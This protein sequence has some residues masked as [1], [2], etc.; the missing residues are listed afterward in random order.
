M[1]PQLAG[2][3]GIGGLQNLIKRSAH[4]IP[5]SNGANT[6]NRAAS[7][8]SSTNPS[9]NSLSISP[10]LWNKPLLMPATSTGDYTPALT[11]GTFTAPDWILVAQNG[12]NPT[13][14][15]TS[16]IASGTS[17]VVGRYA[18]NIYDE[19]GLLDVNVAGY[20]R[21]PHTRSILT[22]TLF[23]YAD[24]TQ[25]GL[26]QNKVDQIVG[27]RNY[28]TTQPS[29]TFPNFSFNSVSAN[30]YY[31]YVSSNTNGFLTPSSATYNAATPNNSFPPPT[32]HQLSP[33]RAWNISHQSS[34]PIS[35]S[36]QP[37]NQPALLYPRR[38]DERR[39]TR[40]ARCEPRGQHRRRRRQVH[41]PEFSE[42]PGPNLFHPERQLHG[43]RRRSARQQTIRP[44]APGMDHLQRP[45]RNPDSGRRRHPGAHQQ[46]HPLVLSPARHRREHPEILRSHLGW[47]QESMELRP[48]QGHIRFERIIM[49]VGRPGGTAANAAK[50]VQD[51]NR[52]PDFFELL[53]AGIT[54]GSL[55]KAATTSASSVSGSAVPRLS[56][57]QVPANMRYNFD[58]SV[59]YHVIQ[60]G[61][62]ILSEVNPTSYPIRI[63][64]DDGSARGAW[65]FQG[66]TDLPYLN[67]VL[68]GVLRTQSPI[69][70]PQGGGGKVADSAPYQYPIA[71]TGALIAPGSATMI[72]V[73]A[74]WN[75]V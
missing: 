42:C 8:N 11:S 45:E 66:V 10:A 34:L 35:H 20:P 38:A 23:A 63:T 4:G 7:V 29:G 22:K 58:S 39:G 43:E 19:G 55:G 9:L 67:Y 30:L 61:A 17:P 51:A 41:Q 24:L 40:R 71:V 48:S 2:S 36:L 75:S 69:P 65:E 56:Q 74:V 57:A 37:R 33:K 15:N 1:V 54:V 26:T 14:W 60:I 44:P 49:L 27:W 3:S 28:A 21:H 46:R 31:N 25:L 18:Y 16:L 73:P 53:K 68:N 5:F 70:Q 32:P 72:Q 12:S 59:D 64:F 62:N 47:D 52:E 50:Y 6:S 13:S